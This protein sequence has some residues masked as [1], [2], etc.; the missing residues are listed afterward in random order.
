MSSAR[1]GVRY[2]V[3]RR[4]GALL[5]NYESKGTAQFL[6]LFFAWIGLGSVW[7]RT[8]VLFHGTE[9]EPPARRPFYIKA[10]LFRGRF[11]W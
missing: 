9:R 1:H 2:G 6:F 5:V 7:S 11:L 4:H 3:D 10:L 8:A